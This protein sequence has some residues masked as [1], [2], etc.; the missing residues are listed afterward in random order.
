MQDYT[1][2]MM[3]EDLNNG[4]QIYYTFVHNRYL[5]YKTAEN[6]TKKLNEIYY[7]Y[8]HHKSGLEEEIT[9]EE[10]ALTELIQGEEYQSILTE[11]EFLLLMMKYKEG[12]SHSEIAKMRNITE[13][14]SKMKL[15]RIMKK[16][17]AALL[18]AGNRGQIY[19]DYALTCPNELEIVSVVDIN[20]FKMNEEGDK[21]GIKKEMRFFH[22]DLQVE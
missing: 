10:R 12:Y 9:Y 11:D 21:Y 1:F 2:E 18:G 15:S 3:W 4:Y 5:I 6:K 13:A 8:Y 20:P 22:Q 19:C 16:L 17:K 7:K 14:S